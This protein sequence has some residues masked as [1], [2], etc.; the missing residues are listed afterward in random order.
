VSKIQPTYPGLLD[1]V[2]QELASGKGSGELY[3]EACERFGYRETRQLWSNYCAKVRQRVRSQESGVRSQKADPG[4]K[5]GTK[6]RQPGPVVKTSKVFHDERGTGEI[7]TLGYVKTLEDALAKGEV[8]LDLW[9][10]YKHVVNSWEVGAKG[11]DGKVVKTPLWQVKVWLRRKFQPAFQEALQDFVERIEA[12]APQYE[13]VEIHAGPDPHL[14]VLALVDQH[15]GKLAWAPETGEAYDLKM[16]RSTY[17]WA[18]KTL[19]HRCRGYAIERVVLPVGNDLFHV[20]NLAGETNAGTRQDYDSRL[21]KIYQTVLDAVVQVIE[22]LRQYVTVEIL[23]VPGNHDLQTSYYL[24]Q[25]LEAYFRNASNIEVDASPQPR[26]YV[27][28]GQCLIGYTHGN[29]EPHKDLPTVMMGERRQDLAEVDHVEWHLGHL[30]KKKETSF[31]GT[32]TFGPVTVRVLPSLCG[33]DYWHF[34]KGYVQHP[35]AAEGFLY[36]KF[37]GFTGYFSANLKSWQAEQRTDSR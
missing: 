37:H 5:N 28:Y 8:D 7:E 2:S 3:A 9:E 35:Q 11:P 13:D 26:K 18:A 21:P 15:F 23:W 34:K 27:R 1:W 36:S 22:Y 30:H 25:T 20:D 17:L 29:E 31:V 4:K 32:D 12:A 10:P 16:A 24:C 14:L 6:D 19:F 33:T